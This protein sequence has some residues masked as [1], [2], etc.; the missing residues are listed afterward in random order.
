MS[1]RGIPAKPLPSLSGVNGEFHRR[2]AATGELAFQR[3]DGCA[4]LRH[5][6]RIACARCGSTDSSFVASSGRGRIHTWTVTHQAMHPAFAADTPY[7]VVVTELEEGVRIV[8]GIREMS[9]DDLCLDLP[10][11]VVLERASAEVILPYVR[12]RRGGL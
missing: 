1:E 8:T 7:A 10:V 3:C 5:P 4:T 12:P 11:E 2:L 6:P 9:P